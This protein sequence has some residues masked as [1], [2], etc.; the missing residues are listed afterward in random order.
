MEIARSV[1]RYFIAMTENSKNFKAAPHNGARRFG[2][3]FW[4][5]RKY[6]KCGN[7]GCISHFSY[8]TIGAKDPPKPAVPTQRCCLNFKIAA[9][10]HHIL[11]LISRILY[12]TIPV[13]LTPYFYEKGVANLYWRWYNTKVSCMKYGKRGARPSL[14]LE[15]FCRGHPDP[16][17]RACRLSPG[18]FGP[19]S[20]RKE[21]P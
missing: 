17:G 10:R 11:Y 5:K 4:H 8:C 14:F 20:P 21:Y 16:P 7:T 18:C 3:R 9:K 15:V 6:E 1:V 12:L 13:P 19:P 2:K